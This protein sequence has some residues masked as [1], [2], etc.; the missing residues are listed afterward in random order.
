[1]SENPNINTNQGETNVNNK[2]ID[3]GPLETES[4]EDDKDTWNSMQLFGED[5]GKESIYQSPRE[6]SD[7]TRQRLGAARAGKEQF[8]R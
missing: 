7:E 1:M 4:R 8:I 3:F 5:D 6:L 2:I